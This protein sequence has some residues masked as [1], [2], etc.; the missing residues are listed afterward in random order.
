MHPPSV[1]GHCFGVFWSDFFAVFIWEMFIF[2]H[3][4]A[5]WFF[6]EAFAHV[7]CIPEA[8]ALW[9]FFS[10]QSEPISLRIWFF[11]GFAAFPEE[12]FKVTLFFA[13][14]AAIWD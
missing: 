10:L 5:L 11:D 3:L 2:P 1:D 4:I 13:A 9:S 7:S 6:W 8:F 14:V 12:V